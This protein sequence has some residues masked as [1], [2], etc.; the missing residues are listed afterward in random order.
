MK[1][2]YLINAMLLF[3]VVFSCSEKINPIFPQMSPSSEFLFLSDTL[4]N[5]IVI[6]KKT[7]KLK[8]DNREAII[9]SR[10]YYGISMCSGGDRNSKVFVRKDGSKVY[11][12]HEVY[13]RY[14]FGEQLLFDFNAKVGECWDVNT[15]DRMQVC[16]SRRYS[17][18]NVDTIVV[19]AVK[20]IGNVTDYP[21]ILEY[22]VGF[23]IGIIK[24]KFSD[25]DYVI[26]EQ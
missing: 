6:E 24:L 5:N 15:L 17:Y 9:N 20:H 19:H 16:V 14:K 13:E 1:K 4:Y 26:H 18:Y 21:R 10:S 3:S 12:N 11:M 8:I 22:H 25:G 7:C 2:T 23:R